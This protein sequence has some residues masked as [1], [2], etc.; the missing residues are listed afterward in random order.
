MTET[1]REPAIAEGGGSGSPLLGPLLGELLRQERPVG[2]Y[3][4]ASVLRRRLPG[5]GITHSSVYNLLKRLAREEIINRVAGEPAAYAAGPKAG[6]VLDE[7]MQMPCPKQSMREE[8]HARIASSSPR[9]ASILLNQIDAH[10][11][12][13][14]EMLAER[15][16][17]D[18]TPRG[19]WMAL[20][21]NLNQAAV[22]E[23]LHANIKF[24]KTARRWIEE[25]RDDDSQRQ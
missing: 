23:A 2:A 15:A 13:C 21:I 18:T 17:M 8:L 20:T 10:E 6:I 25:W 16:M 12:E 22:D 24:C 9:H 1:S 14:F 7:W 4:L 5:W 11:K 3:K 19:S